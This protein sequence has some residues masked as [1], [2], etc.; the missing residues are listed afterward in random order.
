MAHARQM[1]AASAEIEVRVKQISTPNLTHAGNPHP[2]MR[3]FI[4]NI[5]VCPGAGDDELEVSSCLMLWRADGT[6]VE[7]NPCSF[8]RRDTLRAA[9]GVLRLAR[10]CA[11]STRTS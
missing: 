6:R 4:A 3:R 8:V 2:L 7:T 10:R 5:Q 11:P 9:D 1:R